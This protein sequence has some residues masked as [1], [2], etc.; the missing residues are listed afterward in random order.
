MPLKDGSITSVDALELLREMCKSQNEKK[1]SEAY[2][3]T[4]ESAVSNMSLDG[5][6]NTS[7][8]STAESYQ[9]S[10]ASA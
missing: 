5:N 8:R 6:S 9:H 2:T 3:L 4:F 7:Q 10:R 1:G